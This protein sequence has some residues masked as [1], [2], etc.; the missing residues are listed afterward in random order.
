MTDYGSFQPYQLQQDH[1]QIAGLLFN[2]AT[3]TAYLTRGAWVT[4]PDSGPL[5]LEPHRTTA[6]WIDLVAGAMVTSTTE[7][8][9]TAPIYPIALI[10]TG[11]AMVTTL[12]DMRPWK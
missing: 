1:P 6:V 2:V 5:A 10:E 3:G 8:F 9:P 7:G 11:S 4:I 12:A